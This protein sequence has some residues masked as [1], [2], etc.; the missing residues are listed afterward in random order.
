M[1]LCE[2]TSEGIFPFVCG[3]DILLST[4]FPWSAILCRL[5][6]REGQ[7]FACGQISVEKK[8][9]VNCTQSVLIVVASSS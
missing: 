6:Q 3:S 2:V 4:W 8:Y 7:Y 5:R 1:I 9:S